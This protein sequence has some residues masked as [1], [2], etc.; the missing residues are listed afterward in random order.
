M[1]SI[2]SST[3]V[4]FIAVGLALVVNSMSALAAPETKDPIKIYMGGTS[5]SDFIDAVFGQ[6]LK[7]YGYQIKYVQSDY[8]AHYKALQTG[9][10]DVSLGAWQTVPSMTEEAIA[11][12]KVESFGPTGVKVTEGWWFSN[13]LRA[14]C[15]G[16][17]DWTALKQETCIAALQTSVTAP[18]GQ[19][20]DAPADWAVGSE[21]FAKENDLQLVIVPSASPGSL[22]ASLK[23]ALDHHKPILAWGY[24]PHWVIDPSKGDFVER[25]GLKRNNDVL[26]LANKET[27][28]KVPGMIAI[29]EAFTLSADDV[30]A[31][32]KRIDV[33]GLDVDQAA[34][35]WLAAHEDVWRAWLPK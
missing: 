20:V 15:P 10:I 22:I 26:K 6:L 2:G 25:P 12:G 3:V 30:R 29:L 1:A 9:E 16:L 14:A 4:K 33:G 32:M 34:D 5:D 11:S 13:E 27:A 8:A 23:G 17:P 35:D 24:E 31:A 7:K 19:F 28:N 18:K 21:D